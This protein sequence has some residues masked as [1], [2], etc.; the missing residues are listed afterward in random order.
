MCL[1]SNKSFPRRGRPNLTRGALCRGD[2]GTVQETVRQR[3]VTV[4]TPDFPR[5]VVATHRSLRRRV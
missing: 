3:S 4:G 2:L 1:T 5:V